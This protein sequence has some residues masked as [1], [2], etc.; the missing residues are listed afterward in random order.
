MTF[1]ADPLALP[2]DEFRAYVAKKR[3]ARWKPEFIVLH[4]T[5]EPSLAQW[6]HF[7]L[8]KSAA[9]QRA[10]NLNH[11]YASCEGWHSG[12]H[13]FVAPDLII[14]ACDLESDGVHASCYNRLSIG[15][16][17]VGD[18]G[19]EPFN[20]GDGAKVRDN[21]VAAL[22]ILH[23][24]LRIDPETLH[25]HR[26]C[27]RDAHQCPGKNVSQGDMIARVKTQLAKERAS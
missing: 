15:V 2:I 20:E 16:E 6:T 5:A 11:Y 24:A 14:V 7:G 1:L 12:P 26:Q 21:A 9:V 8:G 10:R 22:A 18:Y 23:D 25:F 4:N 3:W 27:L 17:M 19:S 13:L